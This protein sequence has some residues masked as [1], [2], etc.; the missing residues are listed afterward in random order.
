MILFLPRAARVGCEIRHDQGH[1][2][3]HVVIAEPLVSEQQNPRTP[4]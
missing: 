3:D 2:P 4:R 1:Q